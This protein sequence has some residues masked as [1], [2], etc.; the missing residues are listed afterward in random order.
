MSRL[1]LSACVGTECVVGD[2]I[3]C[4]L[5]Q[6]INNTSMIETMYQ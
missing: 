6:S 4:A 2:V 1:F 3:T 5:P